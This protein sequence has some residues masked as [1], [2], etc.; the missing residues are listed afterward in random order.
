MPRRQAPPGSPAISTLQ[1]RPIP[2]VL[3]ALAAMAAGAAHGQDA[4]T[5]KR[6]YHDVGRLR[7]T[8]IS[9]VEC[10]GGLPGGLHGI[11]KA[12]GKPSAIDYAINAIPQMSPLRGRLSAQDLE[13]LASYIAQ[14]EVPSPDL[15]IATEGPARSPWSSE[16]LEFPA[17]AA[18]TASPASTIRLT[19]AGRLPLRLL[20]APALSGP[21]AHHFTIDAGDCVAGIT[22]VAGQSCRI[23]VDF[24]PLRGAAG[25]RSARVNVAHDWLGGELNVALIGRVAA[26]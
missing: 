13:D 3:V 15:R 7:G 9:C 20:S 1:A 5:G 10:H 4:L 14:P 6:L 11:G 21:D 22:L 23:S 26:P 25:Q 18:G 19:N 24:R 8:G 2:V 17:I 12:G 16:R